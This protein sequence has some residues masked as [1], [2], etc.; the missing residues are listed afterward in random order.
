MTEGVAFLL[1]F[2][3]VFVLV[4]INHVTILFLAN[5]FRMVMKLVPVYEAQNPN[6]INL[7]GYM[8]LNI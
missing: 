1:S 4:I 5:E 3:R 8:M 7:V 6:L 2:F